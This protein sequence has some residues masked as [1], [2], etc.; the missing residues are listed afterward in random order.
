M[1]LNKSELLTALQNESRILMHLIGKIDRSAVDYRPTP[2]QRS[3]LDVLRYLSF[4]GP[5]LVRMANNQASFET[6]KAESEAANARNFDQT[7]CRHRRTAANIR[8]AAPRHVGRDASRRDRQLRW[9]QDVARRLHHQV[10]SAGPCRVPDAAVSLPEVVRTRG[11]EHAKPVGRSRRAGNGVGR[12]RPNA[13][14]E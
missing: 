6:W 7:G 2:K 11:V 14:R 4:M 12:L 10:R 13:R 9:Q 5:T 3:T 1:V 8:D